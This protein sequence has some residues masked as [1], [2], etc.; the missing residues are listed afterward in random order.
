MGDSQHSLRANQ[1]IAG[2]HKLCIA[3]QLAGLI[4]AADGVVLRQSDIS[5]VFPLFGQVIDIDATDYCVD[6]CQGETSGI[7]NLFALFM[8]STMHKRLMRWISV[9]VRVHILNLSSNLIWSSTSVRM[10]SR[11][12][13]VCARLAGVVVHGTGYADIFQAARRTM[14]G[15]VRASLLVI[16]KHTLK[17]RLALLRH[18]P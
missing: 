14:L 17:M 7:G 12:E 2:N 6:I 18:W 10:S 5:I 1:H 13:A 4:A 3:V 9:M 15:T 8:C 11:L 16:L